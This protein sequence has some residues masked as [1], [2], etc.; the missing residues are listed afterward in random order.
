[1]YYV[2][3]CDIKLA[4]TLPKKQFWRK[5]ATCGRSIQPLVKGIHWVVYDESTE[6]ML[7]E[8]VVF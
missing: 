5:I 7:L 8:Y 4:P 2:G 3:I 1:M 6:I